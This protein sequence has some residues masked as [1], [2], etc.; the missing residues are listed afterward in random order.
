MI[1]TAYHDVSARD[2]IHI[3]V[4]ERHGI[5][6]IFSFDRGFDAF[7]GIERIGS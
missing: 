1:V 4:M 7:P 6:Q 2:A 5:R 3:A